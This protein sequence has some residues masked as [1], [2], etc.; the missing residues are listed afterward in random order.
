MPTLR[1]LREQHYISQRELAEAAGVAEATVQRMEEGKARTTSKTAS[2]VLKALSLKIGQ[3]VTID[4]IEGLNLYNVMRDRRKPTK[5][6]GEPE[7][8]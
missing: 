1:E 3:E 5:G 4:T 6:S 8:A 7:A 2:K